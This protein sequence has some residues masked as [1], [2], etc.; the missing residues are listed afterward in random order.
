GQ[1]AY[2]LTFETANQ[3]GTASA[4][5]TYN[6]KA[7]ATKDGRDSSL[8][9][10]R[11]MI[12]DLKP[13][14]APAGVFK[15]G[16]NAGDKLTLELTFS[17]EV[18]M[19]VA[20]TIT[21]VSNP[22]IAIAPTAGA[23]KRTVGGK[24]YS[25]KWSI[26]Y[27]LPD[28]PTLP[29]RFNITSYE[30]LLGNS[31]STT[32]SSGGNKRGGAGPVDSSQQV[33]TAPSRSSGGRGGGGG[34]GGG[35]GR[36]NFGR[37]RAPSTTPTNQQD[38]SIV[39]G[40]GI[41]APYADEDGSIDP[42]SVENN[43]QVLLN[44]L[45]YFR[46]LLNELTIQLAAR[47]QQRS[48]AARGV[49]PRE[50]ADTMPVVAGSPEPEI[51]QTSQG[52][53]PTPDSVVPSSNIPLTTPTRPQ[54]S[55]A[56]TAT[57]PDSMMQTPPARTATQT[58]ARTTT[59]Q[60][61]TRTT[62]EVSTAPTVQIPNRPIPIGY[63]ETLQKSI[64]KT[65]ETTTATRTT[66]LRRGSE[67]SGVKTLQQN[68][69]ALGYRVSHFGGEDGYFG[70][71]VEKALLNFQR[72]NGLRANGIYDV[73]TQKALTERVKEITVEK[74]K[75]EEKKKP[76][77]VTPPLRRGSEGSGVKTLQ[78][79]LN[80]LGYRVSEFGYEKDY[81]GPNVE[82]ALQRFQEDNG[83]GASGVYN[84]K[85]KKLLTEQAK[86][87]IEAWKRQLQQ[88]QNQQQQQPQ[89]QQSFEVRPA[90]GVGRQS[91]DQMQSGPMV[92]PTC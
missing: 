25:T 45:A 60:T 47:Q 54:S 5:K 18:H 33:I 4:D 19:S 23:A 53:P 73:A 50:S 77:V 80:V 76:E 30:D 79:N 68:L 63:L 38:Y 10:T 43:R 20:P 78:Q 90:C 55:P 21:D 3:L 22:I 59:T 35:G 72:A 70:P 8:S 34:G 87:Q 92:I 65:T 83:L 13:P 69:N 52:L 49:T 14:T 62:R 40:Q 46:G 1:I 51:V 7:R 39:R 15:G 64:D 32:I 29:I 11:T 56:R 37:V 57:P 9:A 67:G 44:R 26:D 12:I 24:T 48:L 81:F 42:R 41:E 2:A 85:T 75:E 82:N 89:R 91:A 36:S 6:I 66:F 86:A 31:G 17:E 28:N 16:Q 61:P 84:E 27:T 88:Q 74:P 58:P 71:E